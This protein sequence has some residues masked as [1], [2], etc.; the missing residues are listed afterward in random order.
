MHTDVDACD[1][2]Q[3]AVHVCKTTPMFGIFN[4]HTDVDACDCTQGAVHVC[5][6]IYTES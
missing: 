3:G 2:T 5:K 1:C 4:V 6:T